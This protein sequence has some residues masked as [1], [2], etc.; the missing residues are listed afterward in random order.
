MNGKHAISIDL[1]LPVMDKHASRDLIQHRQE[2]QHEPFSSTEILT[3][4]D[5]RS[6]YD[7]FAT[8][9]RYLRQG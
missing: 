9:S 2:K 6:P 8:R 1:L 5:K 7:D 4:L 3:I